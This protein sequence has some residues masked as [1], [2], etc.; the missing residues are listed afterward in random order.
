MK[1]E[2][3]P[4]SELVPYARNPRNNKDAVNSV[5][6]SIREFGF[7]QPIVV[8]ENKTIVAGHTRALAA[9][10]LG[11]DAVPCVVASDLTED[12][13]RAY[14]II[15]N[16]SAEVA[17][18][19]SELLQIELDS[20]EMDLEQFELDFKITAPQ[21]L[22]NEPLPPIGEGAQIKTKT[23]HLSEEQFEVVED[24]INKA[25]AQEAIDSNNKAAAALEAICIAYNIDG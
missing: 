5:A 7:K 24:A 21:I 13:I 6:A 11:I 15:D 3:I 22:D 23:F 4:L 16:K 8:D 10:K 25:V 12:Q 9:E 19:D 2:N 20:I 14:R 18:W 17:E 1:I